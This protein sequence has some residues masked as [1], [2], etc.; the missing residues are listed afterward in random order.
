MSVLDYREEGL[1]TRLFADKNNE[2][3]LLSF[4]NAMTFMESPLVSATVHTEKGLSVV[5]RENSAIFIATCENQLGETVEISLVLGMDFSMEPFLL[6]TFMQMVKNNQTGHLEGREKTYY[7][8]ISFLEKGHPED[9]GH[10]RIMALENRND[11]DSGAFV[12]KQKFLVYSMDKFKFRNPTSAEEIWL[13]FLKDPK[14]KLL[15]E[16]PDLP[17]VIKKAMEIADS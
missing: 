14:H 5:R 13:A 15:V 4:L 3:C 11:P 16:H 12:T 2:D 10:K 6:Q 8:T 7:M 17:A 1:F 9:Q